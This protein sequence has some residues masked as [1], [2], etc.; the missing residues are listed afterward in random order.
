MKEYVLKEAN[1]VLRYYDMPG[2]D[3]P[4]V[5]IHGLGC[6]CS[7]DY[8]DVVTQQC[9]SNHRRILIDLLGAGYSDKPDDFSYTVEEHAKYIQEFIEYLNLK[10]F[11]LFG[12]SL[13]GSI[14]IELAD[15]CRDKVKKIIL[16]EA[17]LDKSEE[18]STSKSIANQNMENFIHAGY[19]TLLDYNKKNNGVWAASMASWIPKAAYLLSKSAVK[20]GNPSWRNTLYSLNCPRTYI[21]GENSLP[22]SD[23][24]VLQNHGIH[25]EIVKNAGHSMALENP[26]G[27]AL[28]IESGIK[29][30]VESINM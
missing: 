24:Q 6:T 17:N 20:G 21:F 30:E 12:H 8:P 18:G 1:H 28:A 10:S 29:F 16:T 4:I 15:K 26:E 5:F 25:V 23:V 3:I 13:G 27:L 19:N 9:L 14:A 22:N 11:I 2:K 7:F